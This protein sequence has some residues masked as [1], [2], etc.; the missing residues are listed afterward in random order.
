M[1]SNSELAVAED[2]TPAGG[3]GGPTNSNRMHF[4]VPFCKDKRCEPLPGAQHSPTRKAYAKDWAL[5]RA[6]ERVAFERFIDFV[7]TRLALYPDLHIYHFAPYEP[8]CAETIDGALRNTRGR[9]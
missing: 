3:L 7:I 6:E 9:A 1:S 4:G 8:C 2:T 5:S